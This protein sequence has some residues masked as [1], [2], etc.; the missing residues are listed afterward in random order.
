MGSPL[1]AHV[2]CISISEQVAQKLHACTGPQREDR[3]GDVLDI[4]LLDMLGQLDYRR[5]REAAEHV[6]AQ[7]ATHAFPPST[8]LPAEWRQE[9]ESL[10]QE[11]G[12]RITKAEEIGAKFATV[13]QRI[14]TPP[15]AERP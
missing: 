10:A 11:L 2:R 8:A 3:A 4:L 15:D 7:R 1:T 14:V 5:A 6:F 9:L 13:V 12:Y